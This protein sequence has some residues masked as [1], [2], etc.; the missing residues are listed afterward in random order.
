M[1]FF[2]GTADIAEIRDLARTGQSILGEPR[3]AAE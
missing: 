3:V 1:K 2:I